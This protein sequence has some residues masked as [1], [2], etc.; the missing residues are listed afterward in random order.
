MYNQSVHYLNEGV[1]EDIDN[2]LSFD[3]STNSYENNANKFKIKLPKKIDDN[4][5]F[6]LTLDDYQIDWT[7]DNINSSDITY[8]NE[9]ITSNNLKKL[10]KINQSVI[11]SNIQNGVDLEYVISGSKI[12][13]NIILNQ[14]IEN[15]S[16]VFNYKINNLELIQNDT[17]TYVFLNEQEDEIF[18]FESLFMYDSDD[19]TSYEIE[20]I[21][22]EV[23][24]DE[25][26]I[27]II[28]S[29]DFLSN[30]T[31]PVIIDPTINSSNT[32]MSIQDTYVSKENQFTN[33][34]GLSYLTVS[35]ST[36]STEY[37]G[38]LRF[39]LP[40]N[41][42]DKQVTYAT[43][44]L[45]KSVKTIGRTLGLYKNIS[46]FSSGLVNWR[47]KPSSS[48]KMTDYHVTGTSDVYLFNITKDVKDWINSGVES[49]PGYT[50]KDKEV[51]G[52]Y[53]SVKSSENTLSSIKPQIEIGY[54]NPYGVKDYWTYQSQD[55]GLAGTGYVSDLTGNLN[56]IRED[57]NFST[58]KQSIGVT[59]VYSVNEE[60]VNIGYGNGWKTNYDI[61]VE[62]ESSN[63]EYSVTD[64]TSSSERYYLNIDC[65]LEFTEE[66]GFTYRYFDA[67]DGSK[68]VLVERKNNSNVIDYVIVT[69]GGIYNI[70]NSNGYL[71]EVKDTTTVNQNSVIIS[72]YS[73]SP[74]RINYI[75]DASNNQ[76]DFVYNNTILDSIELRLMQESE[77]LGEVIQ[78]VDYNIDSVSKKLSSVIYH[79]NIDMDSS[80]SQEGIAYYDYYFD[81]TLGKKVVSAKTVYEDENQVEH[82]H[83]RVIYT[84]NDTTNKVE[85]INLT[86]D[87]DD[88]GL[89]TYSYDNKTTTITDQFNNF[90]VYKFDDFGHTVNIMDSKGNKQVFQYLNLFSEWNDDSLF[91]NEDGSPNYLYNHELI[92]NSSNLSSNNNEVL[93]GSFEFD[94]LGAEDGWSLIHDSGINSSYL[95][96]S[97]QSYLDNYCAK[98]YSDD[99]STSHLEQTIVLDAGIYSIIGYVKNTTSNDD[100]YI[101][102]NGES[103]GG[104]ITYIENDSEW[105]KSKTNFVVEQN[106]TTITISLVNHSGS[107]NAYFDGIQLYE[108]FTDQTYNLIENSSFEYI[109][110]TWIPGWEP[111]SATV[112]R[113]ASTFDL[114]IYQEILGQYSIKIEGSGT[115]GIDYEIDSQNSNNGQKIEIF[116]D[117]ITIGGWAKTEGTPVSISD[118]DTY[119]RYFRIKVGMYNS[120]NVQLGDYI[121]VDFDSSLSGWQFSCN[122][123]TV[124][125]NTEYLRVWI[126]YQGEGSVW[127]DNISVFE[128]TLFT[129]YRFGEDENENPTTE[130]VGPDGSTI[131][132]TFDNIYSNSPISVICDEEDETSYVDSKV[133]DVIT[134]KNVVSTYDKND[135]GFVTG[136]TIGD[137]II[138]YFSSSTT[139]LATSNNQYINTSTDEFGNTTNSYYNTINGLLEAIENAKSVDKKYI[140]DDLGNLERIEIVEDYNDENSE[141]YAYTVYG[142]DEAGRLKKIWLDFDNK[143][144]LYYE[145]IY[146]EI[147]RMDEVKIGSTTLME[148][149][150]KEISNYETNLIDNQTYGNEDVI[151]FG[152]DSDNRVNTVSF[153]ESYESTYTLLYG[154][155]YDESGRLGVTI[156]Y[157]PSNS[158]IVLNREYYD[159]NISGSISRIYDELGNDYSYHYNDGNL[160]SIEITID[161]DI[162]QSISYTYTDE[163]QIDNVEYL[164][165]NGV[166]VNK[167]YVYSSTDAL[168]RLDNVDLKIGTNIFIS[169]DIDYFD[170]TNRVQYISYDVGTQDHTDLKYEYGYDCLGNIELVKYWKYDTSTLS[171][172]QVY[173]YDYIYDELNQLQIVHSRDFNELD[174]T[175]TYTNNT[176]YYYYDLRG[177]IT[178]IKQFLYGE[179]DIIEVYIPSAYQTNSGSDPMLVEVSGDTEIDINGTLNLTYTYYKKNYSVP[180]EPVSLPIITTEGSIDTSTAGY[181]L[182][183][184]VGKDRFGGSTYTLNFGVVIKVGDPQPQT[185]TPQ[186]SKSFEYSDTWLDLLESYDIIKDGTT[187]STEIIY[188]DNNTQ[189]TPEYIKEYEDNVFQRIT[190][191]SWS[192]R[193]LVNYQVYTNLNM[194]SQYLEESVSFTYN[195]K[196]I[197][198]SKTYWNS[199][200]SYTISYTLNSGNIVYET[201]GTYGIYFTYDESGKIVSFNYDTDTSTIGN[202][203]EYFY[204]RNI[205]GDVIAITDSSGLI[206]VEYEYD[207][208][209][210]IVKV[211]DTSN[212]NL[213]TINPIKYRGY[214]YDNETNWYY[215]QSRYYN[216][217]TLRF[218]NNDILFGEFTS[219]KTNVFE[220]SGNNPINFVDHSGFA[221]RK[222]VAVGTQVEFSVSV[223]WITFSG[224]I[225]LVWYTSN[226]VNVGSRSRYIPF[227]Y[228]YGESGFEYLMRNTSK[229]TRMLKDIIKQPETK[230]S[231]V[232][233]TGICVSFFTIYGNSKSGKRQFN[234]PEDYEGWFTVKTLNFGVGK[235]YVSSSP[236]CKVYGAGAYILGY[237]VGF[238]I[239]KSYYI[240]ASNLFYIVAEFFYKHGIT[241]S[242]PS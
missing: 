59:F 36:S 137:D 26:R 122:S 24:K 233:S 234:G 130:K 47:T 21:V 62:Y 100:V 57:I 68:N 155:E 235:G 115:S 236:Y 152:Y 229:M 181:Y 187:Y 128:G 117:E 96:D 225:E 184:C 168:K 199:T 214:Y 23:K 93:N 160:E 94:L 31:Y 37:Q 103:Y 161:N 43:L 99:S 84:L 44:S 13:E 70:F 118:T 174:S 85:S 40:S 133:S 105:H 88:I 241:L 169:E 167:D 148:Y 97:N 104:V 230:W 207:S 83:D 49:V 186:E 7:I 20:F 131:K 119:D 135:D 139:T 143:P 77:Q 212:I 206:L 55:A 76:I 30:A 200:E 220:Y 120:S 39:D 98:I 165:I 145:I 56:I 226:Q 179:T 80:Y 15:Y 188:E 69:P 16:M 9:E 154:Y 173:Q 211:V 138:E 4:K 109:E 74:Y 72:R 67:E 116:D 197:R 64:S 27:E 146:D 218:I 73:Y 215:L 89:I 140:Y 1:Y 205:Q 239:T 132:Y 136:R 29:D 79:K 38:L 65:Q 150:Y 3:E 58:A 221:K 33:Y 194:D 111:L 48:T 222:L 232:F 204:I 163:K 159:Y 5:N 202:G 34:E 54:I 52:A 95:R 82:N 151:S 86:F 193:N 180:P 224:G 28:P 87:T 129:N 240:E 170:Y 114:S 123:I 14:Y 75:E 203:I 81:N 153:K 12:K 63:D 53:N 227:V 45:T 50:I 176:T 191:L 210:N 195:D 178:D 19:E 42:M 201:D 217:E 78:K 112:S 101:D 213:S 238:S 156:T 223:S 182:L 6:K 185:V 237:N 32:S 196:N 242:K 126:E 164:T 107:G 66:T 166:T 11:Y 142:Y 60:D 46:T 110:N 17:G 198:T 209:G 231:G 124:E 175:F 25:Y 144:N 35:G 90:I 171:L 113:D 158:N 147:G 102:V 228:F 8:S 10:T 134:Y 2:T 172:E 219:E 208:W 157:D 141:M 41:I 162:K 108:G 127:F 92:G 183:E 121:Y 51:Y 71:I 190:K 192:G 106:N 61:V 91:I 177:N 189:G 125:D 216:P 149:N 22:T 18:S